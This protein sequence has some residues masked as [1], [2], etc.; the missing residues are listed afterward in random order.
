MLS[1]RVKLTLYYLAILSIILF[2]SGVAI[3]TYVSSTL[4]APIDESLIYQITKTEQVIKLGPGGVEPRMGDE[5]S[6]NVLQLRPHAIQIIDDSWQIR[7]EM[8]ATLDDHL[9]IDRDELS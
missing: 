5:N 8:F 2:F 3:Y 4:M 6:E 7:D 1:L 9:A